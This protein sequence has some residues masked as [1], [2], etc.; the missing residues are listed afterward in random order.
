MEL[1]QVWKW[2]FDRLSQLCFV[3]CEVPTA[4]CSSNDEILTSDDELSDECE[5]YKVTDVGWY[6]H[7]FVFTGKRYYDTKCS[8]DQERHQKWDESLKF[9]EN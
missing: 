2:L 3:P 1:E 4:N 5:G 7:R 9:F 6:C 8:G